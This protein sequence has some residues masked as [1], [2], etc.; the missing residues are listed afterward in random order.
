MELAGVCLDSEFLS[1]MSKE[2]ASRLAAL[3]AEI[4][5]QVGRPFNINSTQQLAAA[6]FEDLKLA[7]PGRTRR[8]SSGKYST[9]A[10]VLED[11]RDAHPVVDLILE[12]REISKLKSTYSDALP[13]Q[14]NPA[15]GRVH[16]SYSQTGSITGRLASSDP[17]LQNIPIRTELGR[18]IRRAFVAA[19]GHVLL[20]VDYSQIEL[21]IV[22]PGRARP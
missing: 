8:T 4:Y 17:N 12:Q 14:V 6:L 22:A 19:P 5:R 15:T 16:T 20:S 1:T 3:E 11:L 21:R 10:G 2:L 18:Q 9:A 7:P 13:Y